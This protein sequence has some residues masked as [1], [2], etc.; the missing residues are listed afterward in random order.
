MEV[1]RSRPYH[2]ND[3]AHV[4]QK[5]R[6]RVR[7]P[8]GEDRIDD[9]EAVQAFSEGLR[10]QSLLDNLFTPTLKLLSKSRDPVSGRLKRHYEKHPRTPAQRA[11]ESNALSEESRASLLAALQRHDPLTLR[12]AAQ[13]KFEEAWRMQLAR[14]RASDERD[15]K[16]PATAKIKK[17]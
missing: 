12:G 13:G 15:G 8:L 4:E 17:S 11:L 7:E 2:K 3:N 6:T 10:L 14:I 16:R 9:M 5:N 1:T